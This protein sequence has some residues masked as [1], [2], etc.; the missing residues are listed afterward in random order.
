[1][2][3]F[4]TYTFKREKGQLASAWLNFNGKTGGARDNYNVNSITDLG[5]GRYRI[6]FEIA[7]GNDAYS[8]VGS[9][10]KYY[11]ADGT[12]LVSDVANLAVDKI[13]TTYFEITTAAVSQGASNKFDPEI[14]LISVFGD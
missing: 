13:T 2:S 12:S 4:S 9:C 11:G 3:S 14:V 5:V 8:V 10:S 7:M 1:M 6:T